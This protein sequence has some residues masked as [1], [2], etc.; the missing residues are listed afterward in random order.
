MRRATLLS[1]LA[2]AAL[3]LAGAGAGQE[4]PTPL[5]NPG[6]EGSYIQLPDTGPVRGT[7]AAGWDHNS[8]FGDTTTTYFRDTAAPHGGTAC[9]AIDVTAVRGGNLQLL[10]GVSLKGG[11]IYTIGIWLRGAAGSTADLT[12]QGPGP[13]YQQLV[14]TSLA[15]SGAWQFVSAQGYVLDDAAGASLIISLNTPGRV[16]VDDVSLSSRQGTLRPSPVAGPIPPQFWGIHVL[17][18]QSGRLRNANFYEPMISTGSDANTIKGV[19]AHDWQD[20][21]DW[22]DVDVSYRRDPKMILGGGRGQA[23]D[24]GAV[25]SGRQQL[26]QSLIVRTG[27]DYIFSAAVRGTPGTRVEMLIRNAEPPYNAFAAREIADFD[28]NWRTYS[29][30]GPVG[31]KGA[32]DLMFASAG[33]GSYGVGQVRLTTADGKPAPSGVVLPPDD[34]GMLR[35]WDSGTTWAALEPQPGT[36]L[37]GQLDRWV[38]AARPGQD[39]ILTLGQSPAWASSD[40]SRRSYNGA[41]APA[42]PRDIVDWTR[43]IKT[44]AQ[45]YKGRIKYYEVW[46]EPNDA[47]FY[48]GTVEQLATLTTAA[49]AALKAVDPAARLI[50]APPYSTGYLDRYLATGAGAAVDIIG[51]HAYATP[52]EETARLLANVR[53]VLASR[54]LADKP[55]W[56]TEGASGNTL[57][58]AADA[59]T[60]MVRKYLADLAFGAGNFNWYGWSPAT[61]FGVGTVEPGSPATLTPAAKAYRVARRWLL[62]ASLKAAKIDADHNWILSFTLAG[63][64]DALIAWNPLRPTALALPPGFGDASVTSLTGMVGTANGVVGLTAAPVLLIAR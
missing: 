31:P 52:P 5:V 4:T 13:D 6:F 28:G 30:S 61:D 14:N 7:V 64:H 54:G 40:P 12:L 53:L 17:N 36:W 48:S 38:A 41:G 35:L 21:S 60:Y 33:P 57:T 42:P 23:V 44:V 56:E 34:F 18:F 63:G 29:V 10:Q 3:G 59:A 39:I 62:G 2:V 55:L 27:Q 25:R 49:A 22:A 47:T 1:V 37:F 15:V 26:R 43:Y 51:Y 19:I 50:S 58:P 32:I 24:V 16:C 45:R 11:S 8:G 46:N 9:Q 20:N